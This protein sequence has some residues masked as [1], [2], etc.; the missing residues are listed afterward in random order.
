MMLYKNTEAMVRSFD[1]NADFFDSVDETLQRDTWVLYLLILCKDYVLQTSTD[2]TE[3]NGFTLKRRQEADNIPT[4][5]MTNAD[6]ADDQELLANTP[7]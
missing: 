6:Y 5:S 3:E 4:I 1:G 7:A 2:V